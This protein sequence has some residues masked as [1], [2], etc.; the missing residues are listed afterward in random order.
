MTT[1]AEDLDLALRLADT[2]DA[3]TLARFRARD[4]RVERK[5]DRTPVTDADVAVEDAVRAV[6]AEERPADAVAG[7]ERG[8]EVGAGRAWVLDPIDGTKNFLRG[9][10]A[11]ATLI[12]LV[13]AGT[14]VVGVLSAPALGRRWWAARGA[15]AWT[16]D[17]DGTRRRIAVSGVTE[18]GDAYLSTT[19]LGSWVEHHSR[20]AYLALVDS[21]WENRAFGD[22]WQHCLVAE[23]VIDL[24]V[25]PIVNPWDVAAV[26]VLVEEAG[27]R[28]SDLAGTPRYDT[29]SAL[30]SN[31]VLHDAALGVL[32]TR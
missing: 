16:S 24:A 14:P 30:S 1:L 32:G 18:L 29:G 13:D 31:G 6:L 19:H 3:I 17:L 27:G 8:G 10:P 12:A 25:E 11:W 23:G 20:E 9:V 2:A 4:L 22:F 5:P 7:E 28:F 26:Q 21:C 15:G